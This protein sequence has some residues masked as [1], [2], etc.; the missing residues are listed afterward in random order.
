[1]ASFSGESSGCTQSPHTSR[2]PSCLP[3]GPTRRLMAHHY[4]VSSSPLRDS[5]LAPATHRT[6]NKHFTHFLT[7]T[8]R[9]PQQLLSMHPDRIDR[10]LVQ[11]I[12]QLHADGAPTSWATSALSGLLY[13]EPRLRSRR[14]LGES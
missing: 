14:F 7:F 4:L 11:Y 5:A 9:T 1:M 6:Y 3:S 10:L 2:T 12:E 13:N 8:R